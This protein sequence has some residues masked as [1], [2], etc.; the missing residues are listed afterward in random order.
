[1]K[2][3]V[4]TELNKPQIIALLTVAKT[5]RERAYKNHKET[6]G[7]NA[8]MSDEIANLGKLIADLSLIKG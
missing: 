7:D 2:I 6:Y 4:E 8:V 1:M 3:N 5:Q